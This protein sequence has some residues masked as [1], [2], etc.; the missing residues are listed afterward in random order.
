MENVRKTVTEADGYQPHLIAPEQGYRRLIESSVVSIR[1]PAES[2]VH[3][4][5]K[6][7]VHKA[8][9]ETHVE[10]DYN[11]LQELKQYPTLRVEVGNAAVE[12]LERMREE[13][14]KATLKLV[15]MECSYLTVDFFRKLPQ[16]VEKGGNPTHSLFDRYNDSYLRRVGEFILFG[17]HFNCKNWNF[18]LSCHC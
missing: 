13:S 16:D 4:I 3:A 11:H 15:D 1:G 8:I 9:N 6:D 14:K 7:L 2:A 18:S 17:E 12:S 5:L 10:N